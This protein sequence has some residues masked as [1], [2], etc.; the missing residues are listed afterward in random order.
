[1]GRAVAAV[2][3][4]EEE[5]EEERPPAHSRRRRPRQAEV[6]VILQRAWLSSAHHLLF[7]PPV[8]AS[9]S[10]SPNTAAL[11]TLHDLMSRGEGETGGSTVDEGGS[12]E[13]C[14]R[15]QRVA[16]SALRPCVWVQGV[17]CE[18]WW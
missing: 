6:A 11:A 13:E 1:M 14:E 12:A 5:E 17:Q 9:R 8:V 4:G 2:E 15:V 7:Q 18:W 16:C 3:K 10:G